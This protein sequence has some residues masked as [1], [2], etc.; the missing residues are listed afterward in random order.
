MLLG[1]EAASSG[2]GWLPSPGS[3]RDHVSRPFHASAASIVRVAASAAAAVGDSVNAAV[4]ALTKPNKT[5]V[6]SG[7]RRR[8]SSR[9]S[10]GRWSASVG[11]TATKSGSLGSRSRLPVSERP[12]P[13]VVAAAATIRPISSA[14]SPGRLAGCCRAARVRS[15]CSASAT[16]R[17]SSAAEGP[18]TSTVTTSRARVRFR[19]AVRTP[20]VART[21]ASTSVAIAEACSP[22]RPRTSIQRRGPLVLLRRAGGPPIAS[23]AMPADARANAETSGAARAMDLPILTATLPPNRAVLAAVPATTALA[24]T[25][26]RVLAAATRN[27]AASRPKPGRPRR[28]I[29]VFTLPSTKFFA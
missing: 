27:G 20:G 7:P 9:R 29:T 11:G 24:V 26:I 4:A 8:S 6:P 23:I 2:T 13:T 15:R 25:A 12:R 21:A 28:V 14:S 1:V 3:C 10:R 19:K 5:S 18:S 17:Q 16:S 22:P